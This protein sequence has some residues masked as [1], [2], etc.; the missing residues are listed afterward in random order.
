MKAE[1]FKDVNETWQNINL[2]I[3]T[4]TLSCG[5]DYTPENY[6]DNFDTF[7]NVFQQN[8]GTAAQF[9]QSFMRCRTFKDKEHYL[10]IQHFKNHT[11]QALNAK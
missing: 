9:L 1:D 2:L 10:Y 4:G 7:I 8:C 11:P 3:Y 6:D 5:V